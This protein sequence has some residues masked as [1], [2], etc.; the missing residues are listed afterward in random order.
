MALKLD[1]FLSK[2]KEPAQ[3]LDLSKA[4]ANSNDEFRRLLEKIPEYKI[5]PEKVRKKFINRENV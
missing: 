3:V 4:T 2:K 5:K 1:D